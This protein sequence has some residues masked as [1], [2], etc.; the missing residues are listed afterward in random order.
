[1]KRF[2]LGLNRDQKGMFWLVTISVVV[3]LALLPLYFFGLDKGY[4]YP[5]GWWFGSLI[6]LLAYFTLIS[7]TNRLTEQK[8]GN[9]TG[10]MILN[11]LVRPLCYLVVLVISA[12]CTFRPAW[13]GGFDMFGFWTAFAALLPMPIVV[14]C[15]HLMK[16]EPVK[17]SDE[18]SR[19]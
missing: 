16:K 8:S 18:A 13:F 11:A 15:T 12:I 17:D 6:E 10:L 19:L 4:Q 5:N 7:F 2:Y 9:H 14:L 1:M 3:F